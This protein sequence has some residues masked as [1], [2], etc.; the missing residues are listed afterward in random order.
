MEIYRIKNLAR[1]EK[2]FSLVT[3]DRYITYCQMIGDELLAENDS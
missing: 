3:A 2:L 1:F